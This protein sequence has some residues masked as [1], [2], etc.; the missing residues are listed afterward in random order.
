MARAKVE[1][2]FR[3]IKGHFGSMKTRY[4]GLAKN[5]THLFT[6]L[7]LANLFHFRQRLMA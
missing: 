7:V 6:L 4:R 2:P 1:Y 5:R 3:V